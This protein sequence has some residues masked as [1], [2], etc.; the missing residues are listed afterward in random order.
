MKNPFPTNCFKLPLARFFF[1][2]IATLLLAAAA[3][4]WLPAPVDLSVEAERDLPLYSQPF[5]A[6]HPFFPGELSTPDGKLVNWRAVPGSRFCGE[7]HLKETLE[8]ATSMH[9][10]SDLDLIYDST[11]LENTDA[12]EA[13]K[14]HGMEKGRWCEACHNPLGTLAGAVTP[15][16]SVQETET[17]E[18]GTSCVVCHAV[19]HAEPQVG[20]GALEVDINGI[21]RYGHPAL[22]AA[23]PSRH[24]RDMRARREQPLMGDSALCGACHTEIRP[25]AVSGATPPLNLQDTYEEWRHSPYARA[26]IQ[27]QDCHMSQDPA[28]FVAALKR[29]EKPKKTLSHRFV[30]NNYLLSNTNLPSGLLMSLRG[31]SPSGL[32]RLYDRKTFNAELTK[33][34]ES[35]VALLK[36]AAEV[37]VDAPKVVDGELRFQVAVTNAGAGHALPT[38]PLDQ[39]YL[40]LEIEVKDVQGRVIFHQG[41]FNAKTGEED[42]TA[43]RWLKEVTDSEGK[44]LRRHTLFDAHTLT[45]TRPPIP[46]KASDTVDFRIPLEAAADS[47]YTVRARLWY[48]IALQDIVENIERQGLGKVDVILPPL[49]IAE[50]SSPWSL[51]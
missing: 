9:A 30:G 1:V 15:A 7:C 44:P 8:W 50:S 32:N 11:V 31:G 23:A 22:I 16:N 4:F 27:C 26:G 37:R 48:R 21:F 12:T 5:G 47:I 45:Y 19:N 46:P 29:G 33:T 34:F 18:E 2:F 41:A 39:R 13:G 10:I 17:M 25:T 35:V 51:P 43:A 3:A 14:A 24:A 6:D 36:E 40:W 38:G 42:L 20:N 49:L 28:G